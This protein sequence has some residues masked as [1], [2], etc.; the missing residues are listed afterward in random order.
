[1]T[2]SRFSRLRL[3]L[4]VRGPE[5]LRQPIE[6][7]LRQVVDPE[8]AMTIVDVGLVHASSSATTS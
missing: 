2:A 7:A 8:V 4:C 1:M 5:A 3:A 6:A